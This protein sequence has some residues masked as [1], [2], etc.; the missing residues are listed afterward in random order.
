M[1]KT[2][3]TV[4]VCAIMLG[5]I[6]NANALALTGYATSTTSI[7]TTMRT[8]AYFNVASSTITTSGSATI[9]ALLFPRG[10]SRLRPTST[11]RSSWMMM[12]ES[13]AN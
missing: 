9:A 3:A 8:K 1:K 7:Y 10:A 5:L 11:T 2:I 13:S 6:A 12:T 4:L